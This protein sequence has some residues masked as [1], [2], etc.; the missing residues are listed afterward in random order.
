VP[1]ALPYHI[2][3]QQLMAL[4]LQEEGIGRI[5]WRDWIGSVPAF[6]RMTDAEIHAIIQ[7]MVNGGILFEEEGILAIGYAGEREFG[8]RNF[9]ELFSVFS[10]PPL[11]SVFYGQSEIG[12]V[13]EITFQVSDEAP[14]VLTLAGR[15]WIVNHI[16]GPRRRAYVEPTDLA[17]RS[18]WVGTAQPMNIMLCQAVAEVLGGAEI[19]VNLS[20]RAHAKLQEAREEHP[21]V[22][23]GAT[24]LI[25]RQTSFTEWWNF[26]ER[27]FNAAVAEHFRRV[28]LEAAYDHFWVAVKGNVDIRSIHSAIEHLVADA[29]TVLDIPF[30]RN[31]LPEL[32]FSACV[33]DS[34]LT[35]M[36]VRRMEPFS[37][38]NR[39][40]R[41]WYTW[42]D[43]GLLS[44]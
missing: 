13:H 24:A 38:L 27:L 30:S 41:H 40:T 9:M 43:H 44:C 23:M 29:S 6:V 17:G 39:T 35:R 10:S 16:D 12:Q 14:I 20:K 32:K 4:S 21:W 8:Y 33:P 26:A 34:L 37:A 7:H 18:R 1:P 15:G 5:T 42:L 19:G 31:I 3:A 28:G 25:Q 22:E 11:V 36:L 2:L